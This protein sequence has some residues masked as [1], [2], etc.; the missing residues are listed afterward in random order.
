MNSLK[1]N[2]ETGQKIKQ[3]VIY[4]KS[5]MLE[6]KQLGNVVSQFKDLPSRLQSRQTLSAIIAP[7]T[8]VFIC[9]SAT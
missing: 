6:Q 2:Q 7:R 9:A 4:I 5:R 1:E 3:M 8:S